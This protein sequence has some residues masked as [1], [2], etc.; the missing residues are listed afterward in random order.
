MRDKLKAAVRMRPSFYFAISG[1]LGAQKRDDIP[2][3]LAA[4][5]AQL[6]RVRAHNAVPRG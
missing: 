3:R 1:N 2:L 6:N 4:Y 5:D